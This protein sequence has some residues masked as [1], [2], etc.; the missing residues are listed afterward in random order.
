[1]ERAFERLFNDH[2][3]LSDF[4]WKENHIREDLHYLR[5]AARSGRV[6]CNDSSTLWLRR[7]VNAIRAEVDELDESIPW[8]WWRKEK[9][10][11]QNVHIELIDIF[12]F[13]MSAAAASGMTGK[14]FIQLYYQKRKLNFDR[15]VVGFKKNDN[16]KL[17][18]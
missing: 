10:D 18:I 9:T 2:E 14:D 7:F 3:E 4:L 13:L 6:A 16:K 17:K 12:H 11:I 1:M 5:N 15:Q 8:K